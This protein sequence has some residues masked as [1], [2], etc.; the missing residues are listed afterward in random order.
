V[1]ACRCAHHAVVGLPLLRCLG[2]TSGAIVAMCRAAD[3]RFGP[4]GVPSKSARA[5]PVE[6]PRVRSDPGPEPKGGEHA[7]SASC[8]LRFPSPGNALEAS[9][10]GGRVRR[11]GR[12]HPVRR[13]DRSDDPP[14]GVS[15]GTA[16]APAPPSPS[17][18]SPA[19][20]KTGPTKPSSTSAS[21][22]AIFTRPGSS[23]A[24][25]RMAPS[26]SLTRARPQ[27]GPSSR[28]DQSAILVQRRHESRPKRSR[29][30]RKLQFRGTGQRASAE[31]CEDHVVQRDR[32][33]RLS[34]L[35]ESDA[36]DGGMILVK[37]SA[38]ATD[39]TGSAFSLTF[40]HGS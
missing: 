22:R 12:L 27:G 32:Q 37:R 4:E 9:R 13:R 36:L 24:A 29:R 18:R 21:P 3:G 38:L 6:I 5:E 35:R 14:A 33:G 30:H 17:R 40:A 1:D 11:H 39:A 25:G 23:W 34:R 10:R 16:Q 26:T 20:R 28:P 31:L 15:A 2:R 7:A 8:L 19:P